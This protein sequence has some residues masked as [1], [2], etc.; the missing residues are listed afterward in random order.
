MTDPAQRE[1]PVDPDVLAPDRLEHAWIEV[2]GRQGEVRLDASLAQRQHDVEVALGGVLRQ[3]EEHVARETEDGPEPPDVAHDVQVAPANAVVGVDDV[4]VRDLPPRDPV[5]FAVQARER[6]L[7][8]R[9]LHGLAPVAERAGKRA[10]PVGL[11]DGGGGR[12]TR[13][14]ETIERAVQI[15]RGRLREVG[16]ARAGRGEEGAL[17]PR[18]RAEGEAGDAV[19]GPA[20]EEGAEHLAEEHLALAE[21]EGVDVWVLAQ[22]AG[23]A[24]G[25]P[26][27]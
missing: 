18:G 15:G 25:P 3:V 4:E 24:V 16:Q 17:G 1:R 8:H 20:L 5:E 2:L 23:G 7:V 10:A 13:R 26:G 14:H 11:D 12:C 21:R 6:Q 9:A 27:H 22:E 19:E